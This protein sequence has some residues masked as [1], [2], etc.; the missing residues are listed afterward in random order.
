VRRMF[1]A[2]LVAGVA[3]AFTISPAAAVSVTVTG[4]GPTRTIVG[5]LA[6]GSAFSD[7]GGVVETTGGDAYCADINT[8]IAIGDTVDEVPW[9]ELGGSTMTPAE[10]NAI[11]AIVNYEF[12]QT[13]T[14]FEL[15]GADDEK[16]AAVQAAI[17]HYA[18][19]FNLSPNPADNTANVLA[20]YETILDRVE[21]AA[22]PLLQPRVLEIT[23]AD[24]S[25]EVGA[26]VA[27][28]VA[29]SLGAVDL[30]ITGAD[31]VDASGNPVANTPVADGAQFYLRRADAGTASVTATASAPARSALGFDTPGIQRLVSAQLTTEPLSTSAAATWSVAPPV[32]TQPTTTPASPEVTVSPGQVTSAPTATNAGSNQPTVGATQV[33]GGSLPRTGGSPFSMVWVGI[34]AIGAGVALLVTSTVRLR[35]H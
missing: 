22:Y 5:T 15:V 2:L 33:S 13:G 11:A 16:A 34:A 19:G 10:R 24:A 25:V 32:S 1:I 26:V 20:N 29:S 17:W 21:T 35:R 31:R 12:P 30:D 4:A 14:G 28:T 8:L 3:L 27:Y 7:L 9:D 18:D 23:P 6:D